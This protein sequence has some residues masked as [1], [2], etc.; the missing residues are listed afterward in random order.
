MDPNPNPFS[1]EVYI[2]MVFPDGVQNPVASWWIPPRWGGKKTL[3]STNTGGWGGGAGEHISPWRMWRQR[4]DE[5]LRTKVCT[6]CTLEGAGARGLLQIHYKSLDRLGWT[7]DWS[8][9]IVN[10]LEGESLSNCFECRLGEE[11]AS[12]HMQIK[13]GSSE[14]IREPSLFITKNTSECC[15]CLT[16]GQKCTADG[17][18]PVL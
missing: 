18:A 3:L 4:Q 7:G 13:T 8:E 10:E 2:I 17:S 12:T 5:M 14:P 6:L 9:V 16:T 1:R 11:A 15:S